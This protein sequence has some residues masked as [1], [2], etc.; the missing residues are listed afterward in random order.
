[1]LNEINAFRLRHDHY[2]VLESDLSE[3]IILK[4]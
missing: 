1:M 2:R 3:F 4:N